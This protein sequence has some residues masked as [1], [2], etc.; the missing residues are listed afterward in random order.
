LRQIKRNIWLLDHI[1]IQETLT[2]IRDRVVGLPRFRDGLITL[3]KLV[4]YELAQTMRRKRV[5]VQTPLA[6]AKGV[7]ISER[8]HLVI[9]GILRAAVPLVEGLSSVFPEARLG[10]LSARRKE[11]KQTRERFDVEISYL[12]VP[13]LSEVDTLII[14]DPMIAT[15]S[16]ICKAL[17]LILSRN[18][19]RPRRVIVAGIVATM[20]ALRRIAS[21]HPGTE[22]Y[23]AA[24]DPRLDRRGYIVPGLGDAGDRAFILPVG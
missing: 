22:I 23:V 2:S 1:L 5:E 7:A 17:D 24:T 19:K 10:F 4:A 6:K 15:G 14:T 21:R 3:G 11:S 20:N 9:V 12:N 16:T 8:A 13:T 18:A